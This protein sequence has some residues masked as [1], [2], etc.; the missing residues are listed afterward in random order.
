MFLVPPEFFLAVRADALPRIAERTV[1]L[2]AF[3]AGGHLFTVRVAKI[4]TAALAMRGAFRANRRSAYITL[5]K[6]PDADLSFA[7]RA[8]G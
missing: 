7:A 8:D 6:M 5:F 4:M 3:E 2:P 1:E